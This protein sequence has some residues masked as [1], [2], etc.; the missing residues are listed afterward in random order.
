M[1]PAARWTYPAPESYLKHFPDL[2]R[3][4]GRRAFEC[5]TAHFIGDAQAA[6]LWLPPGVQPDEEALMA[7]FQR[8]VPEQD[9]DTLFAVFEQM[10]QY[11][12][13]DSVA[14]TKNQYTTADG[15]EALGAGNRLYDTVL[16]AS[17]P[18]ARQA[19]DAL[20]GEAYASAVTVAYEDGRLVREAILTRLRQPLASGLP[21]FVQGSYT[22][23][24]AA[25]VPQPAQPITVTPSFDPRRFALWGEGFGSWGKIASNGN[26]ASLDTSTGGFLLGADAQV[27]DTIRVGVAGGFTR[28][29]FD[30]DGRLSSGSNESVFAA[31]YGSGSWG[32]LTLRLG[33][34]YAWHDIDVNRT[35]RFPGFADTTG[36]SYDGWTAQAF[37]EV[38]YRIG[39]GPVQL[40]PFVGASVLR[41]HT[42]GF[43]EEGGAAALTGYAQDQDLATT[44]MGLRAEAQ[45]SADLPLIARGLVGWRHAYGDVEPEMLLAFAG[46]ASA[47]TV[48]GAPIDRDAL[49]A[50]V[51]LDWQASDAI[52]LGIAY[53]GQIGERAQEHALKGNLVWRFGSY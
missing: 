36:T 34:A 4:F 53:S 7:H 48:A 42:D 47:F 49:V 23:A 8:S 1:D 44:T 37:A 35:V 27:A 21:T 3:I 11:H 40:E 25:D 26:A 30:I 18:G 16:G 5:G 6:A 2:V 28:T 46:G 20:S 22:A 43:A 38:G 50:E 41:L 52:S 29:S 33:A 45:L 15:V 13:D 31:L 12:P 32:A 10:G 17:V 19:F 39:L 9:Q 24:Y 51:G 14:V